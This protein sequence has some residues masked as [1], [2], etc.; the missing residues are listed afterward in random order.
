MENKSILITGG[1][2]G[3]GEGL[4][5]RMAAKGGIVTIADVDDVRGQH[6]A[7]EIGGHFVLTD[8]TDF[9]S[10][11][12]AVAAAVANGEGLDVVILNAGVTSGLGLG[13]DFDPVKYRRVMSINLD[14]VFLGTKRAIAAM[15]SVGRHCPKCSRG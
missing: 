15:K 1:S 9:E 3:F 6:V 14:G 7:D 12:Q 10:N 11:Q 8:V 2:H 4:A 13:D 5:R